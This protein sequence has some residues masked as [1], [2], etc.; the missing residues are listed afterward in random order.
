ML[1][2]ERSTAVGLFSVSALTLVYE[3]TQIRV[4]A[5]SLHPLIAY[6]AI[7]IAMLGFGLGSTLVAIRPGWFDRDPVSSAGV[8]TLGFALSTVLVNLLFARVSPRVMPPGTGWVDPVWTVVA[9]LPC[10]V[11]YAFGGL[12]ITLL[13]QAQVARIGRSYF[14]NLFGSAVGCVLIVSALRWLG[15]ERV[16]AA[17][18]A[19]SAAAAAVL[20]PKAGRV[21]AVAWSAAVALAVAAPFAPSIVAYQPDANDL[22]YLLASQHGEQLVREH[23]EW[24]PVGRIDVVRHDAPLIHVAEPA[25]Y[26]TITNDSGAMSLMIKPPP[27]PGWGKAIFEQS[28]YA[29]PYRLRRPRTVL[30]IGVGGGLDVDTALHWDAQQI[31]GV[32]VSLATLRA[33]TGPYAAFASWPL[34]T[35]RVHLLHE[36]GRSFARSTKQRFDLVQMSGVDTFTMH[37]TGAMVTAED[38]L[39]TTEAFTDFL[40]LLEPDGMLAVTRFGEESMNLSAIAA[41]ALR[42][43]GVQD[44]QD[45][46][47]AVQQGFASAVVV[48]RKPFTPGEIEALR[49]LEDRQQPTA[50]S[51]PHYD[52]AGL[53]ASEPLRLLH[54]PGRIADKHYDDFFAAMAQGKERAFLR[55]TGNPFLVPTDDRPY[56]MLGMWMASGAQIHP[57]IAALR[58][59]SEVIALAS[60]LLILLPAWTVRRASGAR[61]GTLVSLVVF[62][63]GIG[64]A[65]MLLE[66]G[67]IHRT[68][69]FVGSPGASVSVVMTSILMSAGVGSHLSDRWGSEPRR[70]LLVAFLGLVAVGAFYRFGSAALFD[71]LFVLPMWARAVAAVV[72]LAPAGF[73]AGFFFPTGLRMASSRS[74]TLVPWAIAVNGFASVLGSLATL[75][76]GVSFGFRAVF[77]MAMVIYGVAVVALLPWSAR[78]AA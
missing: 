78:R 34:R 23:S 70:N 16:V 4:F 58:L 30:V 61:L 62:F 9:L 60:L 39:Y 26:R 10:V 22:I 1:S 75:S 51:I 59:A 5:F 48:Q 53:R 56:Y 47:A 2:R 13:L 3:L 67:L 18:A 42:R 41:S 72:A 76:L 71:R 17:T 69:V 11:P 27:E 74:R 28:M 8:S 52:E 77:A 29:V 37:S 21:R 73:F 25:E 32:D 38:Y 50:V 55:A 49:H 24:D 36:D 15:A 43:M 14:W 7:A 6:S 12:S 19:L 46:I 66:V 57:V 33:L 45:C 20:A 65:F 40:G 64:F 54:P 35:D 68:V 31:T 63:F 44:P